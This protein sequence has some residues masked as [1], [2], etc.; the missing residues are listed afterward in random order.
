[1]MNDMMMSAYVWYYRYF[2]CPDCSAVGPDW[3]HCWWPTDCEWPCLETDYWRCSRCE[4][5]W[6]T[7]V[8]NVSGTDYCQSGHCPP[9][10][11]KWHVFKQRAHFQSQKSKYAFSWHLWSYFT[12]ERKLTSEVLLPNN[13]YVACT[14]SYFWWVMESSTACRV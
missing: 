5:Y 10:R 14:S 8:L 4:A 9:T 11:E 6:M 13:K 1:M 3:S 12:S 2:R 7:S